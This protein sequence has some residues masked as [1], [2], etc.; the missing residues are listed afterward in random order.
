ME[1]TMLYERKW[2]T[3]RDGALYV[4]RSE[5]A[6]RSAIQRQDLKVE[7]DQDGRVKIPRQELDRR[8]KSS[9]M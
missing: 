7:R 5:A 2:F 9:E 6:I 3:I 8:Y 4:G 1:G